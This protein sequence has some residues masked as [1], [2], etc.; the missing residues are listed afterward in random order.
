MP[1]HPGH[2]PGLSSRRLGETGGSSTVKLNVNQIPAHAHCWVDAS[3]DALFLHGKASVLPEPAAVTA[4]T[5]DGSISTT[6]AREATASFTM[7]IS[8]FR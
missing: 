2:G 6:S 1:A 4:S 8:C 7:C 3:G 5:A